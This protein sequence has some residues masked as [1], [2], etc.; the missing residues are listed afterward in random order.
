[1]QKTSTWFN[2]T[3]ACLLVAVTAGCGGRGDS[4]QAVRGTVTLDGQPLAEG[5]ISFRP[6]PG[7]SGNTAGRAIHK[8]RFELPAERGLPPGEYIVQ[9]QSY[10]RT[11]RTV[12]TTDDPLGGPAAPERVPIRFRQTGQLKATVAAD[13]ENVFDF[14]LTR[15]GH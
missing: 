5:T 3:A 7:T 8:G 2:R 14:P 15:A 9:I 12:D 1:L 11:G 10:E 13:G 6:A 4:R